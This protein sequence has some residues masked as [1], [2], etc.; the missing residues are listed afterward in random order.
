MHRYLH[1]VTD[2]ERIVDPEGQEFDDLPS[3]IG[4]ARQC[5]RDLMA[6][7][8]RRGRPLPLGWRV[9]VADGA[10]TIHAAFKFAEI[11]FGAGSAVP[12]VHPVLDP[13]LMNRAKATFF[14]ARKNQ[15]EMK[16]G[17]KA[18]WD[19]VRV[20]SKLNSSLRSST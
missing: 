4:E 3:A 20:L 18:L 7:E 14:K 11:V 2:T 19:N 1:I 17:L 9:Q 12:A 16:D 6:E 15:I 5:A 8:L 10:G 13:D